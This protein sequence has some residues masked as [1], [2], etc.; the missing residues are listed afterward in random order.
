MKSGFIV[1][2]CTYGSESDWSRF[3]MYLDATVRA[4]LA[5][6][7]MGEALGRIDWSVQE[8]QDLEGASV[9]VVRNKFRAWIPTDV[10]LDAKRYGGSRHHACIMVERDDLDQ[11]LEFAGKSK[12]EQKILSESCVYL[13]TAREGDDAEREPYTRIE[14]SS[15]MPRAYSLL[16]GPGWSSIYDRRRP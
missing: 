9:D 1:F 8:H 10:G 7:E 4:S 2:R 16:E 15:L 11:V 6:E 13:V 12:D 3:M 14:I 5:E